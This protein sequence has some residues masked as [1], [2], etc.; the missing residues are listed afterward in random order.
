MVDDDR[1]IEEILN[2]IGDEHARTVLAAVSRDPRS[3]KELAEACDLS[4]PTIYRR[5]D[6]LDDHDL[7]TE[8]TVVTDEGNHYSVYECNFD[9]TVISLEDDE[10]RVRIYRR[11]NVPD[12]F[13]QLW[14]ELAGAEE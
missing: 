7:V 11:E 8:R 1:P 13:T 5:L 6:L 2:T 9:S 10:Y 12:R 14:D 4:L 3:A